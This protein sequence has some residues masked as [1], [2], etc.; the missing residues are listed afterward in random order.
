MQNSVNKR[1]LTLAGGS[2][3]DAVA[4]NEAHED[5]LGEDDWR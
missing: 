1:G 3:V 2:A 4:L 5:N